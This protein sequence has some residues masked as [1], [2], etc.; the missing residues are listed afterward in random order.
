[1]SKHASTPT[2]SPLSKRQERSPQRPALLDNIDVNALIEAVRTSEL[3]E[4]HTVTN[5]NPVAVYRIM[6][7]SCSKNPNLAPE[8]D[9]LEKVER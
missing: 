7:V 6:H 4:S 3:T 9:F 1:M 5:F 2:S 8:I